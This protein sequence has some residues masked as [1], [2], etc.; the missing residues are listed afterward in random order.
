MRKWMG[1]IFRSLPMLGF[2]VLISTILAGFLSVGIAKAFQAFIASLLGN[3]TVLD[4]FIAYFQL[5]ITNLISY[6]ERIFSITISLDVTGLTS[7]RVIIGIIMVMVYF[8]SDATN[9]IATRH[10]EYI[11]R[12]TLVRIKEKILGN[13]LHSSE[14]IDQGQKERFEHAFL[15][16]TNVAEKVF[17]F[18]LESIRSLFYVIAMLAI[19]YAL[20]LCTL[21][22]AVFVFFMVFM[23]RKS[24]QLAIKRSKLW[25]EESL[26]VRQILKDDQ[27]IIQFQYE[28]EEVKNYHDLAAKALNLESS[29]QWNNV[30]QVVSTSLLNQCGK[31]IAIFGGLLFLIPSGHMEMS[32]M[33]GFIFLIANFY[34][35]IDRLVEVMFCYQELKGHIQEVKKLPIRKKKF[36]NREIQLS[37]V[38]S[39]RMDEVVIYPGERLFIIGPSGSGK[40]TLLKKLLYLFE[41]GETEMEINHIQHSSFSRKEINQLT[42]YVNQECSYKTGTIWDNLQMVKGIT[43]EQAIQE[44]EKLGLPLGI[45]PQGLETPMDHLSGGQ[46]QRVVLARA[47]LKLYFA[48]ILLLDEATSALD[49]ATAKRVDERI[50]TWQENKIVI[51][52]THKLDLSQPRPSHH[53]IA[54]VI[55]GKLRLIS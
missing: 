54:H 36:S 12:Y 42:A 20:T 31:L 22:L 49:K 28:D 48:P 55:D 33:V 13:I 27:L 3:K 7:D 24:A 9:A 1:T 52:V 5:W 46:R 35:S 47:F 29:Y 2:L 53:K 14:S 19:S 23:R 8:S 45:L 18:L 25:I 50:Q 17:I 51:E 34:Y 21:I 4:E 37:Q 10:F 41:I 40:S 6:F 11:S 32:A 44:L 16:F 26:K 43:K 15:A 30:K 38:D 39:L